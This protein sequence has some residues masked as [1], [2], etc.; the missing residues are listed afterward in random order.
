MYITFDLAEV[1][2]LQVGPFG[3]KKVA[4][5][6]Y[7]WAKFLR[8][9]NNYGVKKEVKCKDI[10]SLI[11]SMIEPACNFISRMGIV[12]KETVVLR[13]WEN[14]KCKFDRLAECMPQTNKRFFFFLG[15]K[16][17]CAMDR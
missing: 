14:D 6:L 3:L 1:L 13:R 2:I 10:L 15:C 17:R 12:S 8:N 16:G 4:K 5:S 9:K 11:V 7:S